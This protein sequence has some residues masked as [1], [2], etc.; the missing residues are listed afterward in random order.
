MAINHQSSHVITPYI[1]Y[2]LLF[3]NAFNSSHD[4]TVR[5]IQHTAI[6]RFFNIS[7]FRLQLIRSVISPMLR[8]Q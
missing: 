3:H 4:D 6:K 8:T 2:P 7:P 5:R 1:A